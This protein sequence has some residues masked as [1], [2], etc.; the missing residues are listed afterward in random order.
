MSLLEAMS[1]GCACV[2][3]ATCMIPEIIEHGKDGFLCPP[4]KPEKFKEY[5]HLLLTNPDRA[6]E[7]GKNAREKIKKMFNLD[8]F[9]NE[10]N[11]TFGDVLNGK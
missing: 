3:A 1:C 10:W 5:L 6:Q 9:V 11:Q 4:N 7:I 8:R 2:S